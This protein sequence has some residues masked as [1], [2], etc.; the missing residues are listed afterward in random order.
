MTRFRA[1]FGLGNPGPDY[2]ETRHN[3]GFLV[4]QRL[5]ET[6][7]DADG[8]PAGDQEFRRVRRLECE[9]LRKRDTYLV[10]PTTYMNES[11]V[12]VAEVCRFYRI[13][14]DEILVVYDDMDLPLG[15]LRFRSRGSSGGHNGI[16]SIIQH[17][18]TEAFTRLKV[19]IGRRESRDQ[20]KVVSH[21]L[22][23]FGQDERQLVDETLNRACAA[24]QDAMTNGL[25]HAM[26]E[27]HG[28]PLSESDGSDDS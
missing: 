2:A 27:F 12:A 6:L 14:T 11:G 22:G 25:E 10:K 3:A 15:R 26:T 24:I 8:A 28:A 5:S 17:L 9:L 4:I 1:I 18:G 20:G 16:K 23:A 19:G 21:V 7:P 13:P